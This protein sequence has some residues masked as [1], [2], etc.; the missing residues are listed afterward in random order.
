MIRSDEGTFRVSDGTELYWRSWAPKRPAGRVLIVHGMGEHCARYDV[1]AGALAGRGFAVFSYDHRGHGRSEG[2]RGYVN[3]FSAFTNDLAVA[4][5]HAQIALPGDLP[6]GWVAHS[7]GALITLKY[8][9]ERVGALPDCVVLSAP[10]L[11]TK[12]PISSA[13][14]RTAEVLDR[15]WPRAPLT[16]RQVDP[17][18][19]TRDP[20]MAKAWAADPLIHSK[21]TPRLYLEAERTQRAVLE[22]TD[23][24]P[25]PA[26][27]L[28]PT[29]DEVVDP[30]L[31]EQYA[32]S[33]PGDTRILE[34]PGFRHEPFNELGREDVYKHVGVWLEKRLRR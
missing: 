26:F 33:L 30:L 18:R 27:F 7:M 6:N 4:Y 16:N 24:L 15:V 17:Y 19:L 13:L 9:H 25:V 10:W 34:L 2:Q 8:L 12:A 32:R 22:R 20:V 29:D 31:S 14:R 5:Q 28:I 1:L 21:V 11:R 3:R 23:A